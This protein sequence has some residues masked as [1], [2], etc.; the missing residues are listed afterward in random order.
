MPQDAPKR[1]E[2]RPGRVA[3]V[4]STLRAKLP[5]FPRP[6]R[7]GPAADDRPRLHSAPTATPVGEARV[8]L[9]Q[10]AVQ[11]IARQR[12]G[13]PTAEYR[14]YKTYTNV[15]QR[16]MGVA[17]GGGAVA[18]PDIVVVQAP[19]NYAKTL[20]EVETEETVNEDI[21]RYR[22][23]PFAKA[24]PLYLYVP[25]GEGD[26][27]RRL[28]RRLKVSLVGIRTWRYAAGVG[29]IEINDHYTVPSGLEGLLPGILRRR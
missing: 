24:A 12:F 27:A 14:D 2:S 18:Y 11:D 3:R 4:A 10:R 6:A 26:H 20:A 29:E 5:R 8:A 7:A 22:W 13:F 9:H 15:P 1:A 28:C 25:V 23:L 16:S 19:Q 21:A 17:M